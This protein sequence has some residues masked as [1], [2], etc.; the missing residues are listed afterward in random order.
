MNGT[1]SMIKSVAHRAKEVLVKPRETFAVI[2]EETISPRDLILNYLAILAILPAVGSIIGMSAVGMRV[3]VFGTF[4]VPL[5]NSVSSAVLQYILTL[6]GIYILGLII[7]ALAPT[8]SGTKSKV[9]AL[10][11]AVY[12]ATP[13][14]VAG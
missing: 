4:R 13:T 9:Q 2:K 12:C 11:V 5:I 3:S 14:L 6:A 10:K 8:F 7:N 1:A